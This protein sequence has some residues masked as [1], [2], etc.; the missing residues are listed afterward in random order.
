MTFV[1]ALM[2]GTLM[3]DVLYALDVHNLPRMLCYQ[4]DGDVKNEN[5]TVPYCDS[6][7]VKTAPLDWRE[8]YYFQCPYDRNDFC[9]KHVNKGDNDGA[10][11]TKRGCSGSRDDDG[12]LLRNGCFLN[13]TIV[14]CLCSTNLCNV[15]NKLNCNYSSIVIIIIQLLFIII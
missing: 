11:T 5:V 13:D 15:Q 1:V 7:Y 6:P 14:V 12:N 9:I 3:R 4:C 2:F 8:E 10:I